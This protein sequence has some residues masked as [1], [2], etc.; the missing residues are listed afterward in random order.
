MYHI[1]IHSSV[2]GHLGFHVLAIVNSAS[3]NITL[4]GILTKIYVKDIYHSN[5]SKSIKRMLRKYWYI[6]LMGNYAKVKK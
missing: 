4:Q 1:F 2:I 3:V 5:I 6:H